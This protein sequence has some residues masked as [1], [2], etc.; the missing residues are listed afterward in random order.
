MTQ[1]ILDAELALP[2]W[3]FRRLCLNLPGQPDGAAFNA[4]VVE[5]CVMA[6]RTV[7]PPFSDAQYVAFCDLSGGGADD[8]TLAIACVRDGKGILSVLMDQGARTNGTFSPDDT[9]AKFAEVCKQY[10][11]TTII[12][13]RYAA[14]WPIKAFE[15]HGIIYRPATRN[16]SQLYAAL[17]PL[18]NSGQVELLDHPKLF[19]QLIGLVRKGEKI[20][21]GPGEHDDWSNA[22][23]GALV[24]LSLS[25]TLCAFCGRSDCAGIHMLGEHLDDRKEEVFDRHLD[26][27]DLEQLDPADRGRYGDRH[28]MKSIAQEGF[29]FPRD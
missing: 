16:R 6:E 27:Y 13:D 10:R 19:S 4:D 8:A 7:L 28:V 24:S 12:G 22:C 5:G 1:D 11:C 29:W 23:A 15:K 3:I 26:K 14:Q 21:H 2:S 17:E 20:D 18:L 25:G 9:V